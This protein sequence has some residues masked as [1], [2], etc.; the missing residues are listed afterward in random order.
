MNYVFIDPRKRNYENF[1]IYWFFNQLRIAHRLNIHIHINMYYGISSSNQ[2][3]RER[4]GHTPEI[5]EE[6]MTAR[7]RMVIV[8]CDSER[9][10]LILVLIFGLEV[11]GVG[12]FRSQAV[13]NIDSE[14]FDLLRRG[15]RCYTMDPRVSEFSGHL[16]CA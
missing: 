7:E 10:N 9:C 6:L 2:R 16:R 4:G 14:D 3:E 12:G 13:D 5:A 8:E 11:F 15:T 1:R